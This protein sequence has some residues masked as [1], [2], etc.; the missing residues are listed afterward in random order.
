MALFVSLFKRIEN[1][2]ALTTKTILTK[3]AF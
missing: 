1:S 3:A 2:I